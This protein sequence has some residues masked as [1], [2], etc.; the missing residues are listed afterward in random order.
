MREQPADYQRPPAEWSERYTN[1]VIQLAIARG[2]CDKLLEIKMWR[3][4]ISD[5]DQQNL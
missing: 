3:K 1:R 4:D 2:R 5:G